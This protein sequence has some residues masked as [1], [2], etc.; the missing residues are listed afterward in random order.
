MFFNWAGGG[1][2]ISSRFFLNNFDQVCNLTTY[3]LAVYFLPIHSAS[4]STHRHIPGTNRYRLRY[5]SQN[6]ALTTHTAIFIMTCTSVTFTLA[7]HK[8]NRNVYAAY[9]HGHR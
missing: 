4:S 8:N 9:I 1:E 3:I 2:R 5:L 7:E 6:H